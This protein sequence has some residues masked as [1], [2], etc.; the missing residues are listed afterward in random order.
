MKSILGYAD[1]TMH[2]FKVAFNTLAK[3]IAENDYERGKYI[4]Q[5]FHGSQAFLIPV[6][7]PHYTDIVRL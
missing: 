7:E 2:S 3:Q 1:E 5:K 4:L 6:S